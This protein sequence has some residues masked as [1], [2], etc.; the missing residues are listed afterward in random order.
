MESRIGGRK[1]FGYVVLVA[2]ALVATAL[3]AAPLQNGIAEGAAAFPSRAGL[4]ADAAADLS[5]MTYNVKGLPWP[6]AQ[7]RPEAI[8]AIG[9]RLAA[10]RAQGRQPTVVVLQEAF[11]DEA[12]AIGDRAGYA[13]QVQGPYLRAGDGVSAKGGATWYLGE[14]GASRLDSGLVILS[15]LPVTDVARGAF[16]TDS[17]AG[18]DC[19]AA[20]GVVMVTVDVPG[21]GPVSIAD[22]HLN[23]RAAS[24]APYARTHAA[25]RRQ[26]E[27][28]AQFLRSHRQPGVP[29]ILA[30]DFNRAARPERIAALGEAMSGSHE[31]LHEAVQRALVAPSGRSDAAAI[32]RSAR[33]MQFVFDGARTKVEVSGADVPF[34]SEPNGRDSL[35]D[36]MGYTI[37]YRLSPRETT[38]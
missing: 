30:G 12:K 9:D 3:G 19:L 26:T 1:R 17:C 28:L 16:P 8:R 20:K 38:L 18:Y 11:I 6:I 31:A 13:Y 2:G 34:G 15:D 36:H 21:R 35:S 33:D 25:Y 29:L 7:G 22:T 23:S 10:L 4:P 24:G 37:R 32:H 27:F 5:L 14:T